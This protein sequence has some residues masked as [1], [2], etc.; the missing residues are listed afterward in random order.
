M[1]TYFFPDLKSITDGDDL[2]EISV[3]DVHW[4]GI[5]GGLI[6]QNFIFKGISWMI[7]IDS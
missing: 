1:C 5:C 7:L 6:Q 3:S 2:L 4:A